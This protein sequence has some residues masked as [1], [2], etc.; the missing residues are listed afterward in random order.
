VL[1]PP[2]D[3][4]SVTI[5][6]ESD[7]CGQPHVRPAGV[8]GQPVH[9]WA[10]SCSA[11]ACEAHL[12][13][14]DPRFVRTVAEIP[15]TYDEAKAAEQSAAHGSADRDDIMARALARIAG[16][17]LPA[18]MTRS[19]PAGAPVA[20]L[21]ACPNPDCQKAQDSGMAFCGHCGSPMRRPVPAAEIA[22]PAP[23]P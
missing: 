1:Y 9:P 8:D 10:F 23:T 16:L 20:A 3:I 14:T 6:V 15:L 21:V 4:C 2:S 22:A 19:L 7:G 13:A 12:A 5:P 11:G 18:S 17:E